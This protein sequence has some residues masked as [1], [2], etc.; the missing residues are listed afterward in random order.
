[1]DVFKAIQ[2]RRTIR[3]Y[4]DKKVAM[5]DLLLLVEMGMKAPN[6]GN[7]QDFR[8][9]VTRERKIIKKMPELC[10]DQD[11]MSTATGLIVICSQPELQIKWYAEMGNRFAAQNAAAAAQNILLAAQALNLGAC[12]VG[13][14]DREAIEKAFGIE[15]KARAEIIITVGYPDEVPE[16]K[17]ENDIDVMAYFDSYGNDKKDLALLNKDYSIKVQQYLEEAEVQAKKSKI[18][19]KSFLQDIKNQ[20]LK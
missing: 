6:A 15:G 16:K 4:K 9:I 19:F 20:F 12:W 18:T 8:F 11:W 3:Y 14:F 1:M 5:D 13:G 10:M 2:N 17:T 7:L